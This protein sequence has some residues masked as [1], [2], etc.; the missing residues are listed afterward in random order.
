M[1]QTI[2]G[3]MPR[4]FMHDT[5]QDCLLRDEWN[6][7]KRELFASLAKCE[8]LE[9]IKDAILYAMHEGCLFDVPEPKPGAATQEL[10]RWGAMRNIH[11]AV[12][13]YR[14][15]LSQVQA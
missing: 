8:G 11:N 9:A 10:I 13:A 4:T 12:A 15:I 2:L 7:L 3:N 5:M 6:I 1:A 14:V